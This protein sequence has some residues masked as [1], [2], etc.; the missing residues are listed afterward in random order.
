[1]RSQNGNEY[2]EAYVQRQL[3]HF[4]IWQK[5]TQHRK[6]TTLHLTK[7]K[8]ERQ[9][10]LGC[11]QRGFCAKGTVLKSKQKH[12]KAFR[13]I[14]S[15]NTPSI[16]DDRRASAGAASAQPASLCPGRSPPPLRILTL[17]LA[18]HAVGVPADVP[19]RLQG[20]GLTLA[21]QPGLGTE[22]DV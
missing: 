9:K 6:S 12:V 2:E 1:M 4:A 16:A 17:G 11:H 22:G 14:N 8:R 7:K 3:S 13:A 19:Y 18:V 21:G 20:H 5:F 10:Y 15:C